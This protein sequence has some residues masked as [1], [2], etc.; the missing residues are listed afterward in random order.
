MNSGILFNFSE[1]EINNSKR[2]KLKKLFVQREHN[3]KL[4]YN[5]LINLNCFEYKFW[6]GILLG[7]DVWVIP[8][9]ISGITVILVQD[10]CN[11]V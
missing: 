6:T 9:T 5:C 11:L 1:F 3:I 4:I 2:R 7:A 8:G 10:Y